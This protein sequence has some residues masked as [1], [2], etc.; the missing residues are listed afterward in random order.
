MGGCHRKEAGLV[1]DVGAV[2]V[3][4]VAVEVVM[5]EEAAAAAVGEDQEE[6]PPSTPLHAKICL[7]P[8][9]GNSSNGAEGLWGL[10]V[11][12]PVKHPRPP[13]RSCYR[14]VAGSAQA[15]SRRLDPKM[16]R[17]T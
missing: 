1:V 16:P 11:F 10:A 15:G 9:P 4:V 13:G 12:R 14:R 5:G 8:P 2:D 6:V 3:A 17:S 7:T